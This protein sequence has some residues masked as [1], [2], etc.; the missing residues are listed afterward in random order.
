MQDNNLTCFFSLFFFSPQPFLCAF[1]GTLDVLAMVVATPT[2]VALTHAQ[3]YQALDASIAASPQS[4]AL[5]V[6]TVPFFFSTFP[7][8]AH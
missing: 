8:F 7:P 1:R 5:L 6:T 2:A 4:C 3:F